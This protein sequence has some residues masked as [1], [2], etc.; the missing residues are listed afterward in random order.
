MTSGLTTGTPE[1]TIIVQEDLY[2]TDAPYIFIQDYLAPP[3]FAPDVDGYFWNMSGTATYPVKQLG[4]VLDVSL[5]ENVTMNDV[6]CDTVGVV[7]AIQRR[8]YLEFTLTIQSLFPLSVAAD[9]MN[10]SAALVQTG[11][12]KV[13]IGGINNNKHFMVYMPKVYDE[14]A[15]D[16]LVIHLHKCKFVDA[17]TINMATAEPWKLTGIK[18]RAFADTTKPSRQKFGTVLRFDSGAL[19]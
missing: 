12:E 18:L 14:D 1:G 17:W 16:Y 2:I 6:R 4:C 10:L 5:S 8:E 13:G 7:D 11:S 3:L 15:N 19:P 9:F